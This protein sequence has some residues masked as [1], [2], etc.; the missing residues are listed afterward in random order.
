MKL[1]D[2]VAVVTGSTSGMGRAI[3]K[4]FCSEGAKVVISGRNRDRGQE[5]VDELNG[6]KQRAVFVEGDVG[7]LET[8]RLIVETAR[9]AFGGVDILVPCAGYPWIGLDYRYFSR[10]LEA[11]DGRKP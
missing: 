6:S 4:L 8:N 7:E 5:I 2:Q 9:D 11:D 3:A 10:G 1:R